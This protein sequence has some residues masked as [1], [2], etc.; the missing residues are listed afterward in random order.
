MNQNFKT[1]HL[2]LEVTLPSPLLLRLA[3]V[4]REVISV[5]VKLVVL[6]VLL[7]LCT[8]GL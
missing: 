5:T 6:P 2:C 7:S 3:L 4:S 1:A 8:E